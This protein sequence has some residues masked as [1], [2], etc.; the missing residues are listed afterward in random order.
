MVCLPAVVV[1]P[2]KEAECVAVSPYKV[3]EEAARRDG[4]R[5]PGR[6]AA[7]SGIPLFARATMYPHA[8][9]AF[10]TAFIPSIQTSLLPL[11]V[12][13]SFKG[14]YAP[15]VPLW[16]IHFVMRATCTSH[17]YFMRR[18]NW[19]KSYYGQ[20]DVWGP[21]EHSWFSKGLIHMCSCWL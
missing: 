2:N 7:G 15:L 20:P 9:Q 18:G 19:N 14:G 5:I 16:S 13:Q 10:C 1:S 17:V 3:P 11:A 21:P 4:G 6:I 8:R 12:Q